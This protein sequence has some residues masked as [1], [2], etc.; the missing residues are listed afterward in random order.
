[1]QNKQHPTQSHVDLEDNYN[2]QKIYLY[3]G[4]KEM[5]PLDRRIYVLLG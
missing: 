2:K 5:I 3:R 4:P 1:M